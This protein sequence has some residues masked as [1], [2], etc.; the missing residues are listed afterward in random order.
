MYKQP[1]FLKKNDEVVIIA[2][3]KNFDKKELT[4]S[5]TLLKSWGLNV[6]EGKNLYKKYNQFAGNDQERETDLQEALDNPEIK[7]IF[8]A[9]GGYGTAR[10]IDN[11]TYKKFLENPK[12]IIGFSDVTV[13]H[14]AIQKLKVQS[15]HGIMPLLFGT[16]GYEA[17]VQKLRAILFGEKLLYTIQSNPLN[18]PG[19]TSGVL[20]GGNLSI[21]NSLIGTACEIK[22]KN[23]ILLLEDVG[24]NL[25]R[26]DRMMVQLKR[27]GTL[28]SLS[29][30]VVGHFTAMED[31][32]IKFGKNAYEIIADAVKE[33]DYP[34]CYGFPAGHE[35]DNMP[36]FL[37]AETKLSVTKRN[38]VLIGI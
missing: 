24:E 20:T 9:R 37:G 4:A 3:A 11:I 26:V 10:I 25:Y 34:V 16:K 22:T 5:I 18:K 32:T 17:S 7:A 13:L 15:I 27:A 29:G 2:T 8:C 6:T 19:T 23:K 21:I 35:P 1:S 31:N 30:L 12:W 36:L 14:S 38:T 33:Y 28:K